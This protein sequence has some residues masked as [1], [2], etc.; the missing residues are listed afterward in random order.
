MT[1]PVSAR[2]TDCFGPRYDARVD[3]LS[4]LIEALEASGSPPPGWCER[5][6]PNGD[7]VAL[8]DACEN[9]TLLLRLTTPTDDFFGGV[10]VAFACARVALELAPLEDSRWSE[11]L[12]MVVTKKEFADNALDDAEPRFEAEAARAPAPARLAMAAVVEAIKADDLQH[13][14]PRASA[15]ASV[16][17]AIELERLVSGGR[18][19]RVLGTVRGLLRCPSLDHVIAAFQ[20]THR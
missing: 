9:P 3:P 15:L 10:P 18:S 7:L 8:W 19:V 12:E 13:G 2:S 20:R 17:R 14:E 5:H 16:E 11:L 4:I 6:A 1:W